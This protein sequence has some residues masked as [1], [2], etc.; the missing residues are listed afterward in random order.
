MSRFLSQAMQNMAPY[1]PG[2]QPQDKKYLKLNTNEC[3]YEPSMSVMEA[4]ASFKAQDLR[5]YPDPDAAAIKVVA[6]ETY[7]LAENEVFITGG[8]DEALA[9][10]FMAFFDR[11]DKVYFPDITYG[12]Y[13][14]YAKLFGLE[15][16]EI[17]LTEDFTVNISDYF[18]VDGHIFLANPNA[19]TGVLLPPAQ[20]EEI[21]INNPNKLVV[22]DEAYIDFA[23]GQSCAQLVKKYENLIVVQTFS[24]SRALAGM[25]L[26]LAFATA[27][28]ISA[29]ERVKYSFN[30][31]NIDRVSAVVAMAALQDTD[32][33]EATVLRINS[34]RESTSK[35][36]V[37]IGFE[38]IPSNANFVFAKPVFMPAKQL[39]LELRNKGVLVRYFDKERIDEF[40]RITIGTDEEIDTLIGKIKEIKAERSEV[41]ETGICKS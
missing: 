41:D 27:E 17:P 5:L 13:K 34:T 6:A 2:E 37:D 38:V 30:P 39:Y 9:F 23:P 35:R 14:V 12:F 18:T 33:L 8:S 31:Y 10:I 15:I 1:V 21:L 32:Y 11:G 20:I 7:K 4:L 16:C 36:L 40:L 19:P 26:G 28:L 29:L 25:R 3:P 24:K 22:I